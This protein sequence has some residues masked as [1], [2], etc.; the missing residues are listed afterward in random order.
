MK[1]EPWIKKYAPGNLSEIEGQGQ[2]LERLKGFV[3]DFNKGNKGKSLFLYGLS[4]SG[5]TISVYALA[6][7][8]GYELLEVNASDTRN[9]DQINS[10]LGQAVNQASLFF[11]SKIILVDELEG[12]SGSKDR[13]GLQ[14]VMKIIKKSTYPVVLIAENP[15]DRK[16]SGL[17]K[18]CVLVEYQSRP[19][20]AVLKVLKHICKKENVRYD[21][22]AL[23]V[24]ARASGGDLRAAINDLQSVASAEK[25]IT[26]RAVE[27]FGLR[28]NTENINK[29]L[30]KIFKTTKLDVALSAFD[31]VDEDLDKIFLWVDAN[32]AKEYVKPLDLARGFE[33]LSRAD[34]FKGRIMRW[35]YYRFYVYCYA[36]LSGGIALAKDE[37]YRNL[38]QYKPTKRLLKTWIAN[39]RNAKKKS[40]AEKIGAKTHTSTNKSLQDTLPF[41][42]P[43]FK[44]NKQTSGEISAFLDLDQEQVEW[45]RK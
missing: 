28:D 4:G 25:K 23:S 12:I 15:F 30:L 2:A 11:K 45:M 38:L 8:L 41:L 26:R 43:A 32:L 33:E 44:K 1:S 39:R 31:N 21:E 17:R 5:K 24:L 19:Y 27:D 13:G 37:K 22:E 36:L 35:Q 7:E 10:L 16:F 42:R 29:A 3:E 20:Q 9:A 18:I 40:V 34:V 6:H 14:A